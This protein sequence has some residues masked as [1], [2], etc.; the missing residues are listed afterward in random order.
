[1]RR[2][3][4]ARLV[5][6]ARATI[7]RRGAGGTDSLWRGPLRRLHAALIAPVLETGLLAGKTRL[8]LVPHVELQ[9]VPFAAL[10]DTAGHFLVERYGARDDSVGLVWLALGN[11]PRILLAPASWHSRRVPRR[12]PGRARKLRPFSALPVRTRKS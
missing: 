5:D 11:G 8:V 6:F 7:E 12:C 2:P 9:Y 10:M 4:L 3:E 1:M